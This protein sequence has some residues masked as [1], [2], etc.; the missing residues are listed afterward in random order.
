MK[1]GAGLNQ[2]KKIKWALTISAFNNRLQTGTVINLS[3]L[4]V[5][6]FLDDAFVPFENH[7]KTCLDTFGPLKVYTVFNA[8]YKTLLPDGTTEFDI[9]YFINKSESIFPSTELRDWYN[10]YVKQKTL[11]EIEDFQDKESNYQLYSIHRLDVNINK[12]N[13]LRVGSFID[14]PPSIKAQ[15]ACDNVR[16]EE[17]NECFKWAILSALYGASSNPSRLQN[18]QNIQHQLNFADIKSPVALNDIAKF[19]RLNNISVNVYCLVKQ[20]GNFT[21][22]PIHLTS[23]KQ[24]KHVN[25]LRVDDH[26]IDKDEEEK[27]SPISTNY[28]YVWIKNLSRLINNQV[29]KNEHKLFICD[30]CLQYFRSNEKLSE[31]V[32]D[33]Q[34]INNTK[35]VLPKPECNSIE[36]KNF[37]NNERVPFIVYADCES[38]LIP[39]EN[40]S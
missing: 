33:C 10:D 19:K 20:N 4:D 5:N 7:I 1:R 35:I 36:F 21:L 28:H 27:Q 29:S 31:H 14:L 6:E 38:L 37:S 32:E 23:Q 16:N 2:I 13:P 26:Y 34:K 9:K 25:L 30:R 15:R 39:D 22:S 17:D 3:H 8:K 40:F 18:Y 24:S 11:N 12:Y